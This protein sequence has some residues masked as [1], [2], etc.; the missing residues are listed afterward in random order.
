[1]TFALVGTDT[2]HNALSQTL[3]LDYNTAGGGTTAGNCLVLCVQ[4]ANGDAVT[5]VTFTGGNRDNWEQATSING[6]GGL[7]A[8]WID[9]DCAGSQ[10]T[11]NI[12]TASGASQQINAQLYEFSGVATVSAIDR[13]Q[14]HGSTSSTPSWSTT[15][16]A[17]TR[18]S[19]EV[20]VGMVGGLS[21][22]SFTL[23]GPASPW[24]NLAEITNKTGDVYSRLL[25]G[26]QFS[27]TETSAVYAGSSDGSTY[28][29]AIVCLYPYSA[30]ITVFGTVAMAGT[31]TFGAAGV[32]TGTVA[33]AGQG[34]FLPE[35]A[36]YGNLTLAGQGTFSPQLALIGTVSMA[37]TS[38]FI[39]QQ[40]ATLVEA[41][42]T[43]SF[44][45]PVVVTGVPPQATQSLPVAVATTAGNWLFAVISWHQA[46]GYPAAS[47]SVA[48]DAHN[49]WEP[50]GAPDG[51]SDPGGTVRI[52]TW[53]APAARAATLVMCAPTGFVLSAC[54]LI[55]EVSGLGD[56]IVQVTPVTG[57]EQATT[58]LP[59]LLTAA[60]TGA[61]FIL[62]AAAGDLNS[63]AVTVTETQWTGL[64][65]V[66]ATNGSD[67]TTDITM[68]TAWQNTAGATSATWSCPVAQD[69][70]GI[71]GGVISTAA[72]PSQPSPAWPVTILEC[73]PGAG[74]ATS[75]DEISW[76]RV[77]DP[78]RFLNFAVTSGKQ[79]ELDQLQAAQ[80]TL[81]LD[82]PDGALIPPGT[83]S[84]T[85]IDSGTPVRL[86]MIWPGGGVFPVNLTPHYVVF[87]GFFERWPQAWDTNTQRGLTETT[88]V[89]GWAYCQ[90]V[91]NSILRIEILYDAPYAYWPCGDAQGAVTASNIAPGNT[92]PLVQV[93]SRYGAST[94]VAAFGAGSSSIPGDSTSSPYASGPS[95][96]GYGTT[97]GTLWE[98]TG[99]PAAYSNFGF[100]L[101]CEDSGYPA[102]SD[103]VT[104]EGWFAL[105]DTTT[106]ADSVLWVIKGSTGPIMQLFV[107]TGGFLW[108]STRDVTGSVVTTL[109]DGSRSYL[110]PMPIF[111]TAV[112]WDGGVEG[113]NV[114]VNCVLLA[115]S[116]V[117]PVLAPTFTWISANGQ[118]DRFSAGGMFD[119]DAAHLAIFPIVLPAVRIA[120]H[121][122]AGATGLQEELSSS[123]VERLL[124]ATGYTGRRMIE[125][126]YEPYADEC[127]SADDV[128]NQ[129]AGTA[130]SN[131][132]TSTS[133]AVMYVAP[134]SD[135]TYHVKA[136][137]FNEQV[138]W[139]LG[140]YSS[141]PLNSNYG[142]GVTIQPWDG[143]GGAFVSVSTAYA[144]QGLQCMLITPPASPEIFP[145]G[146]DGIP[147]I[148]VP[149]SFVPGDPGAFG[150]AP[151]GA[152]SGTTTT[153]AT[154]GVMYTASAW[155][156]VPYGW[157]VEVLLGW[158]DVNQVSLG[159]SSSGSVTIPPGVWTQVMVTD[160]APTATVN[161][162]MQI[163]MLGVPT[164]AILLYADQAMITQGSQ[165]GGEI[166]YQGSIAMDY[167]PT[168]V[169]NS[170]QITQLDRQDV[171]TPQVPALEQASANQYGTYT[172][173]ITGYLFN[174]ATTPVQST[175]PSNL[176]DLAN[177]LAETNAAPRLRVN[178]VTVD[179]ASN[180][181]AWP[182]VLGVSPGDIIIVNR[183][184][185]TA[186][187]L[188]ISLTL[189]VT[190]VARNIQFS[191]SGQCC[192]RDARRVDSCPENLALK[193]DDAIRGQLD[194]ENI[195]GWLSGQCICHLVKVRLR[196]LGLRYGP[197]DTVHEA[198][199]FRVL[200]DEPGEQR[201]VVAKSL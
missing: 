23:T 71:S 163:I 53:Y 132:V 198:V 129:Q 73:A 192:H 190:Q 51:T 162:E 175:E 27:T 31:G 130:V 131:I 104:V 50:L 87:S 183:R 85:G 194:D 82:N 59:S 144:Y 181:P 7:T 199:V 180:P 14:V 21:T 189:R 20:W 38:S 159:Y 52:A 114:Y 149:G 83:G 146:Y 54:A 108:L 136:R 184:P 119:G 118:S 100:T 165:P 76:V 156:M 2:N 140:E 78:P 154:P 72:L 67:D 12:A 66:T 45:V 186:A 191:A 57:S 64:P 201:A 86:R 58:G 55:V 193:A 75:P 62:S 161:V 1:M 117:V 43:G 70:A 18:N 196:P 41:T 29:A 9:Y 90:A 22:A 10:E 107:D 103:G 112:T 200:S 155:I 126:A 173:Y 81:Q 34:T 166:P 133:P 11:I 96:S 151:I 141:I 97:G 77:A 30:P 185:P 137:T 110:S 157:N 99:L 69:L 115:S 178:Q 121:Y 106:Y 60:P 182:L 63:S 16:T 195:L 158:W 102:L 171:V 197:L 94:A 32:L 8:I 123:R 109:I 44:S 98:Q 122:Q 148:T 91:L 26:Y 179:A 15:D 39:P 127:S 47:F 187:N 28:G 134:T 13:T 170:I 4:S 172:D 128:G 74:F 3:A 101:Y 142:F 188:L 88:L 125:P 17:E 124:A 167:D 95:G 5:G 152:T 150:D 174:D 89:D 105:L 79:Y 42:W 169:V 49:M 164:P 177:W 80:G 139:I 35:A 147:G 111:H 25:S 168:R 24:H 153:P 56:G 36:G 160:I 46:D 19:T 120:T 37:G 33:M 40:S 6:G 138:R 61:A 135:M 113:W 93:T 145:S 84:F 92:N 48:D 65:Q 116:A 143:L 176:L 68:V